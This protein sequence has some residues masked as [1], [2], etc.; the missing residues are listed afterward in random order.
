V[1]PEALAA[2]GCVALPAG[3]RLCSRCGVYETPSNPGMADEASAL[4]AENARLRGT[5]ERPL[6]E[7][8]DA[9]IAELLDRRELLDA[10]GR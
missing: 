4:R 1:F 9:K 10:A 5:N 3:S 2:D 7:D 8:K 6:L